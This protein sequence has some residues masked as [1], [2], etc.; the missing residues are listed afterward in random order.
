MAFTSTSSLSRFLPSFFY[1]SLSLLLFLQQFCFFS[2][3]LLLL[4]SF[5]LFFSPFFQYF[6]ES[7][8][9]S[10]LMTPPPLVP[11]HSATYSHNH[12]CPY[13]LFPHFQHS[14]TP[15][16]PRFKT[17]SI[18]SLVYYL[19]RLDIFLRILIIYNINSLLRSIYSIASIHSIHPSLFFP[20]PIFTLF[21]PDYAIVILEVIK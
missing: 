19:S 1:A 11:P 3:A 10:F 9:V 13:L 7:L 18:L 6:P 5:S 20:P 12:L 8:L 2:F 14:K 16:F 21:T 17:P 15:S 4:F